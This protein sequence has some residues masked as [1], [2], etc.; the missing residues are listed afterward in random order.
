VKAFQG[1]GL[2]CHLF[3][4]LG[5]LLVQTT[6]TRTCPPAFVLSCGLNARVLRV[7]DVDIDIYCQHV[8]KHTHAIPCI[9]ESLHRRHECEL[10]SEHTE[11][12][13]CWKRSEPE[14]TLLDHVDGILPSQSPVALTINSPDRLSWQIK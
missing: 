14:A 8:R 5:W 6:H 10:A 9:N 1:L 2:S 12:D 4:S 7:F 13:G 3:Y 11:T